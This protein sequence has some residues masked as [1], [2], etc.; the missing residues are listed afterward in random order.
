MKTKRR[1]TARIIANWGLAFISPLFGTTIAFNIDIED[2]N[3]KILLTALISS[4]I[5]T[6]LVVF[7]EMDNYGKGSKNN[8]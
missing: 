4:L 3:L 6:G 5:V 8:Q 2:P 7:R 1:W